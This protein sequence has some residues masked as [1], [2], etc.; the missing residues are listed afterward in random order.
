MLKLL[1]EEL[2]TKSRLA[3]LAIAVG[4][5]LTFAGLL[6]LIQ[7]VFAT[8]IVQNQGTTASTILTLRAICIENSGTWND[9]Y[10]GFTN[11]QNKQNFEQ[12]IISKG[13]ADEYRFLGTPTMG[14]AAPNVGGR[15]TI[16]I[17]EDNDDDDD[18]DDN[19]NGLDKDDVKDILKKQCKKESKVWFE[20]KC[21]TKKEKTARED[22]ICDD[23]D[24]KTTKKDLCKSKDENEKP[25][26]VNNLTPQVKVSAATNKDLREDEEVKEVCDEVGGKMTKDGCH[27]DHDG[28][29]A[30]KFEELMTERN[31]QEVKPKLHVPSLLEGTLTEEQK[32]ALS[33]ENP[34]WEFKSDVN[35]PNSLEGKLTQEQSEALS[36][37]NYDIEYQ[38]EDT[39]SNPIPSTPS[40]VEPEEE[41][42]RYVNPDG[43]APLY[44]DE[45]TEDEKDYYEEYK[46]EKEKVVE[47]WRNEVEPLPENKINSP[48]TVTKKEVN[49]DY[50]PEEPAEVDE[51]A[52]A[53]YNEEEADESHHDDAEEADSQEANNE[54]DEEEE[55][56][57]PEQ[58]EESNED[59]ESEEESEEED[60]SDS[61]SESDE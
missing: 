30:D 26:P 5:I 19:D 40:Y 35:I 32:E 36:E 7:S 20:G 23:E 9:Y 61:E 24:A 28:P 57:E 22:A 48:I 10:C 41:E 21:V 8:T 15:E 11:Q 29:M 13:L 52:L 55:Q 58:E 12:R 42:K 49:P 54:S 37:D 46:P 50:K 39:A 38:W 31:Q 59:E 51:E 6:L 16:I 47:D 4:L 44:E 18:D 34:D 1:T 43:G 53:K 60:N 14:F 56:E 3:Q 2:D 17:K 27:T 33:K 25:V 45:L